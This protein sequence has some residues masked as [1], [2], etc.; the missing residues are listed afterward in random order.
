MAYACPP[1]TPT[2]QPDPPPPG[3]VLE[4]PLPRGR[5]HLIGGSRAASPSHLLDTSSTH[6]ARV[7]DDG[8]P[9]RMWSSGPHLGSPR[10]HKSP[11][12]NISPPKSSILES[13]CFLEALTL[14][15][16]RSNRRS[17]ANNRLSQQPKPF[18]PR[19]AQARP[20]FK[21]RNG[22]QDPLTGHSPKR[23]LGSTDG[24][25]PP[26]ERRPGS[27]WGVI[28][29]G[30]RIRLRAG[31]VGPGRPLVGTTCFVLDGHQHSGRLD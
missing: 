13:L 10:P 29:A 24:A 23:S 31:S 2:T 6:R 22:V 19:P 1:P 5:P 18:R 14:Q 4:A 9:P 25:H 20:G 8:Q 15:D 12:E 11:I 26:T 16:R 3:P 30:A 27:G 28:R 17:H 21:H 7:P